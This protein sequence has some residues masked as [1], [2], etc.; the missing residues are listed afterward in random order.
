IGYLAWTIVVGTE[1]HILPTERLAK[2]PSEWLRLAGR[3]GATVTPGPTSAWDAA[4]RVASRRPDGIDLSSLLICNLAAEAIEPRV[5]DRMLDVGA[6]L[7][8]RPDA[9]S[10]AYGMAEAT[11]GITVA[12]VGSGIRIDSVDRELLAATGA[13][14]SAT[15]AESKRVVSC[16]PPV[17]GTEVRIIGDA[18]NVP[19][20]QVG[21]IQVRGPSLMEGYLGGAGPDPFID[22]WLRTGDLG[23]LTDG[24]LY[25]TGRSKDIIIVMGRNY[26]PQDIEWAAERVEGVR[27]G[28]CVAFGREGAEGE[29]VVAA[30]ATGDDVDGLPDRVWQAVSD[31]VGI[32]PREVIV[33]PRGTVPM[34]TSGKLRRSWVREAYA[35]GDLSGVALAVGSE[36]ARA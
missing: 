22:G 31:S 14:V 28:R 23:Y 7:G 18:G 27:V 15:G 36:V 19:E 17:P 33:L 26:S 10:G 8:L 12:P 6:S 24:E 32:V 13:A 21:E 11:L 30:E 3:V 16:G 1:T 9:P 4:L 2:D 29:V 25:V 5:V 35:A 20:R 34:T